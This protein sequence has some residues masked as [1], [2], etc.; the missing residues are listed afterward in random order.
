MSNFREFAEPVH[1]S[2][3]QMAKGDLF[4]VD[5][6]GDAMFAAY[7]AAF[8]EGTNLIF[9]ER[10]EHDCSCCKSFLR[11]AANIIDAGRNTVWDKAAEEAP[12]PFNE[13]AAAL[14]ELVLSAPI[15]DIFRTSEPN[16]GA[17]LT[18]GQSPDGA[19]ERWNHFYTGP[20]PKRF[21]PASPD[22]ARG[23]YRTTAQ[24]LERGLVELKTEAV[25]TVLSLIDANN[26][27]RGTEHRRAVVSFRKTQQEY[28]AAGDKSLFVW[29]RAADPASRF[30]NTVIGT[31][32]QDLSEGMDLA[33]AVRTFETKVAPQNYKRTK[34]L[35]TPSMVK[36]AMAV[37]EELGLEPA[38]QRRFARI[39][40]IGI[41]DVLWA[42]SDVR[43]QMKGGLTDLLMDA[44]QET[45]S[46]DADEERS[47]DLTIDDFLARVVPSAET[48]ELLFK[49]EHLGNL[50][51]LTAP[52]H[53]DPQQLFQWGND[54]AWSYAGNITDSIKERVRKAG[55]NVT[56][57]QLR[58]SLSWFNYDD[59]DIHVEG[60]GGHIFYQSKRGSCGGT[61]D[62]DMN[63]GGPRSREAVE[64]IAWR[65]VPDGIYV[66]SV[67]NY[68]HRETIDV[69]FVVEVE[70][71]GQLS[72]FN[73]P[74]EV[75]HGH[76]VK[77]VT[78]TVKN[79][80]VTHMEQGDARVT[81][82]AVSQEKWGLKT[83]KY[84]RV[85]A[86]TLSPNHWGDNAVGN[87]HTFFVLE[88]ATNDEP[89]RG[90]YNE[91]LHPR[92]VEHRKVFEVIGD[93]TKC[94]PTEGQLSGLGFSST[95]PDS[96][97]VKVNNQRLYQVRF[98]A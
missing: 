14:D 11:R 77:V 35:I 73:Y 25:D 34:A 85:N 55:G 89:C 1:T 24:V 16:F 49:G 32:V 88:G 60:P 57:A 97:I 17:K 70:N 12:Y 38:L 21:R 92:L 29:T 28:Q 83:E 86:V 87:K 72:H 7:L 45:R 90:I 13:V 22:K 74:L 9:R 56:N 43:P 26:L 40:D 93:K 79:G 30:R 95:K 47:E 36:A 44:T 39:D 46:H 19:V 82:N 84:V 4:V 68:A 51:S 61:L 31:L 8:P 10:T 65:R 42:N 23:D 63:A 64:N 69:G 75:P 53:P 52:V 48:M 3:Q 18:R 80:V 59:L 81:S 5:I 78:L 58:A 96:V 67:H 33:R 98:G 37:V 50:M 2:F 91:F 71:R 41:N 54:F 76:T 66:V 15:A 94:Q 6:D 62:V 20:I 27:Y